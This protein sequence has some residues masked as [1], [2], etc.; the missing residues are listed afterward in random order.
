MEIAQ[1]TAVRLAPL[2]TDR[3]LSAVATADQAGAN[4]PFNDRVVAVI[5]AYNEE[6]FIGSVVLQVRQYVDEV[7]VVDDGSTDHTAAIARL[8]GA[9]VV[10]HEV[11]LGKGAAL[12]T[13]FRKARELFLPGVV[14]IL[15]GDWQHRP[16]DLPKVITPVLAGEADLVIGS[17]Y[18]KQESDVPVS[19][20]LGH[21]GFTTLVNLLSGTAS[22]DSQS[23][24]RAFSL[25]AVERITFSSSGFSVESEMQFLARDY[26]LKVVEVPITIRYEDKPKRS[27]VAH[28]LKVLNGILRLIGQSRPLV[29]FTTPG[30]LILMMGLFVGLWVVHTYSVYQQLAVGTALLAVLFCFIGTLAL[31][32]GIILH[33]LRGLLL[34]FMRM[35]GAQHG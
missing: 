32:T 35:Q 31:F 11:N 34:E 26:N 29:F 9:S 8:A 4:Y 30:F 1:D 24:F 10:R 25:R 14:V 3:L 33:S 13:G 17:R 19:R 7:I 28:G 27:V 15:D 20:I 21:W 16:E 12:N 22:T 18:L 23:G 5:P 2:G 6:R